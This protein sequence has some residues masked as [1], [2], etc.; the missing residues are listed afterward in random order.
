MIRGYNELSMWANPIIEEDVSCQR[1]IGN[2]HDTHAV[3]VRK[4]IDGEINTA[5][6]TSLPGSLRKQI[7]AHLTLLR[8]THVTKRGFPKIGGKILAN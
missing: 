2:A 3:A 5:I 7:K 6:S 8:A 4:T 1:E